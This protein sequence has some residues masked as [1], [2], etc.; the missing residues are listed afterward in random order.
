MGRVA[1]VILAA[2]IAIELVAIVVVGGVLV[3]LGAGQAATVGV[4][5]VLSGLVATLIA[6]RTARRG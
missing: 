1:V 4:G 3:L 2:L 6:W 5:L